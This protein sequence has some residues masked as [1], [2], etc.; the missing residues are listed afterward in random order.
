[1]TRGTFLIVFGACFALAG[2]GSTSLTR[3]GPRLAARP[4]TCDFQMLTA[5]PTGGFV[6]VGTVDVEFGAYGSHQ[7]RKL[8]DFKEEIAPSVCKA[9]GDAAIATVNGYGMYIKATIL[10]SSGLPTSAPTLTQ[11]NA[12]TGGCSFDAQCKGDRICTRGACVDP[13]MK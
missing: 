11:A 7:F 8:S 9:G 5:A 12:S 1:M 6:E 10:K 3:T 4:A 2:C 13:A